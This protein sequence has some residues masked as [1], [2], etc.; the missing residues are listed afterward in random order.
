M[1]VSTRRPPL[2]LILFILA[3]AVGFTVFGV[4]AW[5]SVTVQRVDVTEAPSRF[6]EVLAELPATPALVTRDASGR[7]VR[8][9]S[10][11]TT[12]LRPDQLH[13]LM[14]RDDEQ[15][16]IRADVPLWFFKVK[17][18]AVQYAL[19]GT[20]FDLEALN[21]TASDLEQFGV[22]VVL[23]ETRTNGDRMLAWTQ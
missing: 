14:Y 17:G 19:R 12:G 18:P 9:P 21:L 15:R 7:F 13:V 8:R 11:G 22:G 6:N 23:N 3:V 5:R 2:G 16:L 20:G 4:L 10:S 1:T